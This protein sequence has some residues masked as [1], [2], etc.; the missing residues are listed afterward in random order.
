MRGLPPSPSQQCISVAETIFVLTPGPA[1]G[2]PCFSRGSDASALRKE[3]QLHRELEETVPPIAL[4]T[5]GICRVFSFSRGLSTLVSLG[6]IPTVGAP[7]FS[8]G[9]DASAL[10]K[11]S[12]LHREL[13]ETVP[14]IALATGGICRVF[15][16][17]RGLSTL[18]SLG[19]IPTVGAPCFSRGERRFSVAEGMA[20]S[21]RTRR[22][23]SSNCLGDGR[24]LPCLL[25][26][27]RTVYL[28]LPWPDPHGGSPLL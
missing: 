12:Q 27:A 11:E 8:R 15:S 3:W 28:G 6:Q 14:P 1:V 26:L 7:C 9:S 5:G 23:S 24:D 13:E 22:D 17:S 2:A 19:Q 18:V 10:R 4:A 20:T 21:S 25:I 16:F